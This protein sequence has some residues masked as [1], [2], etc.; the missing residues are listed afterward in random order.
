MEQSRLYQYLGQS[1]QQL[2][3]F[4]LLAAWRKVEPLQEPNHQV[5]F[6]DNVLLADE[7]V[8]KFG[9]DVV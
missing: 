8:L 5:T 3:N 6:M 9:V 1:T 2:Q 4:L 7:M